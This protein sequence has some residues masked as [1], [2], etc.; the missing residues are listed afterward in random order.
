MPHV[1]PIGGVA[2]A[3]PEDLADLHAARPAE[4]RPRR[5]AAPSTMPSL[6]EAPGTALVLA[7]F[8]LAWQLTA[9]YARVQ[10]PVK[11]AA[12]T[13][14]DR[15]DSIAGALPLASSKAG[16]FLGTLLA[17]AAIVLVLLAVRRGE[18]EPVLYAAIGGIGAVALL[19]PLLL[20]AIAG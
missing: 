7:M 17:A 16:G 18:R 11:T 8:A 3:S 14:L 10:L 5:A 12:G 13:A 4:S 2:A 1:A 15:F 6:L 9:F 19:A 20:P